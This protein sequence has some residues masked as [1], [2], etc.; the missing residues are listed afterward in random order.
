MN[1]I[2]LAP[3]KKLKGNVNMTTSKRSS[4]LLVGRFGNKEM[5]RFSEA[6]HPPSNPGRPTS[7][8][9]SNNKCID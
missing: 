7:L 6:P 2:S 3:L 9:Q 1:Y 4:Q 5:L 8:V